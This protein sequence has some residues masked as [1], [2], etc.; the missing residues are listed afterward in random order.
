MPVRAQQPEL[1]PVE[2]VANEDQPAYGVAVGLEHTQ[3]QHQQKQHTRQQ[4]S[5]VQSGNQV[6][7][8]AAARAGA[9]LK[10]D[11]VQNKLAPA[12]YLQAREDA[13]EQQRGPETTPEAGQVVLRVQ[14]RGLA[15]SVATDNQH[16]GAERKIPGQGVQPSGRAAA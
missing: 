12:Q 8:L 10:G 3:H 16:D 7:K 13:A 4:V 1:P 5:D 11:A 9:A 6:D 15:N 2:R 14:A